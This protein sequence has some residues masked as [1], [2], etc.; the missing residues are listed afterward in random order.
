[1]RK[2]E[3]QS[4][5]RWTCDECG[6]VNYEDGIKAEFTLA[7]KEEAY[8]QYHELEDYA[9]LPDGWRDFEMVTIPEEVTC[10]SCGEWFTTE[11]ERDGL[12]LE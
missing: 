7:S 8:R 4:A 9:E 6:Q 5:Y 11:D 10:R 1:M 2:A 12:E 3:L